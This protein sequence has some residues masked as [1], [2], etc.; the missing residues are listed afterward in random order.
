M[1]RDQFWNQQ[2]LTAGT[3]AEYGVF[4]AVPRFGKILRTPSFELRMGK[5]FVLVRGKGRLYAAVDSH[6]LIGGPLH[7]R[8]IQ[9]FNTEGKW[10][11]VL[12]DLT[13]YKGHRLHL[14]ISPSD[15]GPF[16]VGNVV[17]ADV[18]PRISSHQ[19]P[20][21]GKNINKVIEAAKPM[22]EAQAKLAK[23]VKWESRLAP[24]M[25]DL[26]GV[27]DHVHIRGSHLA[28]GDEVPR[29]FLEALVGPK[30]LAGTEEGSGRLALAKQM[31]DPGI[32]PFIARVFVN[33]VWYHLFGQGIVPSVDNFGVMGD[34]P[35]HPELLDYLADRFIQEGWSVKTLIR[36]LVLSRAYG[37]S[38]LRIPQAEK[39]DPTNQLLHSARLRRLEG[40][41]IRDAMLSVSGSL[42]DKQFGKPVPIH[43]TGFLEGRGRPEVD[44]PLDGDGRRSIYIAIRRNFLS[45]FMLAFDTPSPFSTMGRRTVSNVPAQALILMNDPFVHQQAERWGK[46]VLAEPGD[47]E[48]RIRQMYLSA[49]ARMPTVA[50]LRETSEFVQSRGANHPKSWSDLAHVLFNVKE[51]IYLP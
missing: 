9:D 43:L 50:E 48:S 1:V 38:T 3:E 37:M 8:L 5:L 39:V 40:E 46:R 21:S 25:W 49:F 12:Q 6:M 22:F 24:V 47:T 29:R 32:D 35:T 34:K 14:E 26:N 36:E 10:Q 42:N 18:Q 31:V 11:W 20:P 17:D 19:D 45:P 13:P 15:H 44:G 33:R 7:G 51:F 27:N 23:Q 16:E 2:A 4:G 28:L 30:P 41:A